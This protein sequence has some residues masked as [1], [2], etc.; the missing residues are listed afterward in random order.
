MPPILPLADEDIKRFAKGIPRSKMG[1]FMRRFP[2]SQKARLWK[3]LKEIGEEDRREM[4]IL[5]THRVSADRIVQDIWAKWD[6]DHDDTLPP[7][8]FV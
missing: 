1:S 6:F 3:Y 5:L 2:I 8:Q 7:K 4:T